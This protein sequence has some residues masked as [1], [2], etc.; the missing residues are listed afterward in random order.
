MW[1]AGP[2]L[3]V[4]AAGA[5]NRDEVVDRMRMTLNEAV[6][7]ADGRLLAVRILLQ[8]R[9]PLHDQLIADTDDLIAAAR[10][11]A[12]GLG[13]EAAWV[14]RVLVQTVP[15]ADV[16]NAPRPEDQLGDL[17]RMLADAEG[18]EELVA[19]LKADIGRLVGALPHPL[20]DNCEDDL[21][22]AAM[23]GDYQALMRHVMPW[24]HARL[25]AV[26]QD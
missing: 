5:D 9:T 10:S 11:I 17:Q 16:A 22:T 6:Q 23:A 20:R 14:E 25:T 8:G 18:D 7:E 12:L 24:L 21:L 2:V 4:D 1:C 3:E 19:L 13:D 26:E 15:V